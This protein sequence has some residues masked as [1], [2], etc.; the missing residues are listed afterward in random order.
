VIGSYYDN[1][2]EVT[3]AR[4]ISMLEPT[5]TV[6]MAGMGLMILLSVYLPMFSM[7]GSL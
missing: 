5:I 7:Y 2:V 1:E 6:I 4:V 3:T